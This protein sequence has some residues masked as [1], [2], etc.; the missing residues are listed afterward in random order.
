[1]LQEVLHAFDKITASGPILDATF[2]R[3]GH[4]RALAESGT[5]PLY[6]MDR[7]PQAI[8]WGQAHLPQVQFIHDSFD[9]LNQWFA[10]QSLAGILLDLGVSS[11]QLDDA[12]RGFSFQKAGPLDMRM[13]QQ[14]PTAAHIL[15]TYSERDLANLFFTYGQE[16]F[17]RKIARHLVQERA[18]KPLTCTRQLSAIVARHYPYGSRRHAATRVF[19]ALR[20]AV[21]HELEQL[22][23]VLPLAESRLKPGGMLV[24][25]SFHSLED[26]VVKMFFKNNSAF[27]S[28]KKPLKTTDEEMKTNPRARSAIFR[29]GLRQ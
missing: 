10:P 19:Q 15:E 23:S 29:E 26:R 27:L 17:S 13:S 14:G 2:G 3:G 16:R 21:N 6:A 28:L 20:I 1:M 8:A 22:T 5:H 12:S 18:K 11:P 9:H 24:V 7:D 25:I 4:T